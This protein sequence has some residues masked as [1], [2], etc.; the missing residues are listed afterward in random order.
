MATY[1][2]DPTL[3]TVDTIS[4]A[5]F[6]LSATDVSGGA[7]TALLPDE[8]ITATLTR[9]G[10]EMGV[11]A[12]ANYLYGLF[13]QQV[14]AG[15]LDKG[16]VAATWGNRVKAWDELRQPFLSSRRSLTAGAGAGA[17][18]ITVGRVTYAPASP[19]LDE[20]GRDDG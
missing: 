13:A 18:V 20:Y 9:Y 2:Y 17:G 6:D 19:H 8:T 15:S 10:Y 16:T 1:T 14:T 7:D 4:R 5:R 3:P 12:L 11:S